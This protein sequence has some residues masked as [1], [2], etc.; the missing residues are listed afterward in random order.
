[1][2][3]Q[4]NDT[5]WESTHDMVGSVIN[6][7]EFSSIEEEFLIHCHD[8]LF[9]FKWGTKTLQGDYPTMSLYYPY[10]TLLQVS[11]I[12]SSCPF[13]FPGYKDRIKLD[14]VEL[15]THAKEVC[16]KLLVDLQE[17]F[18]T[19]SKEEQRSLMG[20]SS[21]LDS[22][23]ISLSFLEEPEKEEIITELIKDFWNT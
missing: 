8:I 9:P 5:R 15:N 13:K 12:Y 4:D 11:R 10:M 3:N 23:W 19:K 20:I 21:D 6:K 22:R 1:M 17:H 14:H 16:E 18:D 7:F 2:P